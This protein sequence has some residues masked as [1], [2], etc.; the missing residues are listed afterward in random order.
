MT[1]DWTNCWIC[2]RVFGRSRPTTRRCKSC[3][4]AYCEGEHGSYTPETG[5][6]CLPCELGDV[7]I[8]ADSPTPSVPVIVP[9]TNGKPDA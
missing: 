8:Q 5:G 9:E 1:A 4:R 7:R 3:Q 2:E 6:S